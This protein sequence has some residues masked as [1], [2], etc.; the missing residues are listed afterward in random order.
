M[1]VRTLTPGAADLEQLAAVYWDEEPVALDPACR[2]S[3]E[4]AADII[5]AAASG[6]APVYGVNT[7]FG[8]LASLKDRSGRHSAT[9][10]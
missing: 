7:G 3:V 9:A 1:S 6:D 5:T 10:A 8:K 4:A 2:S